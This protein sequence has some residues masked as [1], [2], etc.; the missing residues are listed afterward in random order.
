MCI[1]DFLSLQG[2]IYAASHHVK[3]V[4]YASNTTLIMHSHCAVKICAYD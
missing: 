3:K 1:P 2:I 4:L